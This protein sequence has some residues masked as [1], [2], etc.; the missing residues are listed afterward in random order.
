M[1]ILGTRQWRL[2]TAAPGVVIWES[3]FK[4]KSV[5]FS[6]YSA[7]GSQL[8]LKDQ[9]GN[10]WCDLT[11]TATG[12]LEEVRLPSDVG[13]VNGLIVDTLQNGGIAIVYLA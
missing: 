6:G 5:T 11:G 7:T 13:W 2:D 12:D 8:I 3:N 1:N 4:C 10:I 9:N